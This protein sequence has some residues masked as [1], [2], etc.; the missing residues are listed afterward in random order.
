MPGSA[1][2][3]HVRLARLSTGE[4]RRAHL[5][6]AREAWSVLDRPDLIRELEQEFGASLS[7]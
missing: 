1:G 7:T 6:A 3:A 4:A 5:A 2:H